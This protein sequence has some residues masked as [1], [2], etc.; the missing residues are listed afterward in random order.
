LK[1]KVNQNLPAGTIVFITSPEN[2]TLSQ[3]TG[4]INDLCFSKVAY[5]SCQVESSKLKLVLD[6][7]VTSLST[8]ELYVV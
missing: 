6:E 3:P 5:Q 2:L 1:F 7:D 8:I 4:H